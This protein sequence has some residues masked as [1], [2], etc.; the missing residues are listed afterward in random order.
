MIVLTPLLFNGVWAT[1]HVNE[2]EHDSHNVP[3]LHLDI[4]Q[5]HAL[6]DSVSEQSAV[7]NDNSEHDTH[8]H[9][10][11]Y[12]SAFIKTDD[13][14]HF[15]KRNTSSKFRFDSQLTSLLP[16]PPVPPPNI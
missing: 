12:L 11:I 2:A 15:E 10:H 8:E 16:S 5:H 1:V 9:L 14:K 3:H 4:E 13:L 6:E 7:N